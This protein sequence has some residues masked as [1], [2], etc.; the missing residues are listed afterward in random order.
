MFLKTFHKLSMKRN[1][2]ETLKMRSLLKLVDSFENLVGFLNSGS[3]FVFFNLLQKTS[4]SLQALVTIVKCV[5]IIDC[6]S[7]F[8]QVV[9]YKIEWVV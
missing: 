4:S 2:R 7:I 9:Q 6:P 3:T 1:S 8:A 5:I